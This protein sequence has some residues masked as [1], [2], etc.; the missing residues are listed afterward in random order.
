DVGRLDDDGYLFLLD[1]KKHV[2]LRGGYTVYPREIEEV[3]SEH[4]AVREVAVV[5]VPDEELGEEVAAFVVGDVQPAEV[6]GFGRER[7]AAYKYPRLVTVLDELPRGPTGKIIR[8]AL[9][10]DLTRERPPTLE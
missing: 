7:L 5:G 8:E 6:R 2:I 9:R 3:L 1:R 4:P 10:V